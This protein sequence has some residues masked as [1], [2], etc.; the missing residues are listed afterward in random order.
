VS[1]SAI[2]GLAAGV[3][4]GGIAMV[5]VRSELQ[6]QRYALAD[7]QD[8]IQ[9]TRD[10]IEASSVEREALAS[11]SRIERLALTMGL[12]YPAPDA[13]VFVEQRAVPAPG[14]QAAPLERGVALAAAEAYSDAA[15]VA[16]L[17]AVSSSGSRREAASERAR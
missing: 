7:V 17:R 3:V 2:F 11:P 8:Q 1:L 12:R 14:T 15:G 16:A 9:M 10:A 4:L 5:W 6:Q 13:V